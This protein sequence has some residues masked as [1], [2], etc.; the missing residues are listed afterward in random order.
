MTT[1]TLE[2]PT[3][4]LVEGI[5]EGPRE[6]TFD[7]DRLPRLEAEL[8]RLNKIADKLGAERLSYT[9]VGR[10]IRYLVVNRYFGI[11]DRSVEIETMTVVINGTSPRLPGGWKFL[12]SVEYLGGDADGRL[13]HGDD[14]RLAAYRDGDP[15]CDHCGYKRDRKKVVVLE[16]EAAELT[17]V[18]S[19]C[20]KDFLGYHGDPEKVMWFAEDI[21]DM[22]DDLGDEDGGRFRRTPED[23]PTDVVLGVS[24]AMVRA[25][26]WVAKSAYSGVPTAYRVADKLFPPRRD[27]NNED[28]LDEL[29]AVEVTDDDMAKAAAAKA[30]VTGAAAEAPGNNYLGN[31]AVLVKGSWVSVKHFG[32]VASS[33]G[34]YDKAVGR[35]IERKAKA[36]AAA[37][38][39]FVGTVGKREVF[40]GT[41]TAVI[42]YE[43]M[44]G[45]GRV[46]K[47]AD[48][49]GNVLKSLTSGAWAYGLE[50]GDVVTVKATVKAHETYRGA[51]ETNLTRAALVE[52][53]A[54]AG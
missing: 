23:V 27:K 18:G 42:P 7:A 10:G 53:T 50:V 9:E 2:P 14:E 20:I 17:A 5:D 45:T 49:A 48:G 31:L 46:V 38:S 52:K 36:E 33:I 47:M 22:M 34:A 43:T 44:Y 26:G 11:V 24:A 35:E 19:T 21:A 1:A 4:E 6:I 39:E 3:E 13:V 30:W 8:E 32:L 41:V 25:F 28:Y 29:E 40:T 12:G 54:A 16:N 51:K 15:D 37:V